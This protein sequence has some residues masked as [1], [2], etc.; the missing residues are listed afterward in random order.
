MDSGGRSNS[1][2]SN[3]NLGKVS[4]NDIV[5][6]IS[7]SPPLIQFLVQESPTLTIPMGKDV[8]E[9]ATFYITN[10]IVCHFDGLWACLVDLHK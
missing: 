6:N 7:C 3:G 1:L 2:P 10:G 9:H 8:V 5:N 4:F